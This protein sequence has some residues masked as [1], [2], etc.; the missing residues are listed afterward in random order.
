[1]ADDYAVYLEKYKDI[2]SYISNYH[3]AE[4]VN[5]LISKRGNKK[6]AASV[7]AAIALRNGLKTLDPHTLYH[8]ARHHTDYLIDKTERRWNSSDL[9][10]HTKKHKIACYCAA[11]AIRN[12]LHDDWPM[13]V[14]I[15]FKVLKLVI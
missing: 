9:D 5:Q 15:V 13:L 4:L 1:M 8:A 11:I 10:E 7:A 3:T 12:G 14:K 6:E 2:I